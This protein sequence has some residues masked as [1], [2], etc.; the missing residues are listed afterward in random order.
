MCGISGI[1]DANGITEADVDSVRR[2]NSV[3]HHRGPDDEGLYFDNNCALG[4]RRLSIIDLSKDG[5]QPFV[6]DDGRYY[7]VYNGEIYNYIELREELSK[8]GW[9]FKTRTDTEVLLITYQEY[10]PKCLERLNGM[11]AFVVYDLERKTLF[12]ARDRFGIKPLY[13]A[14]VEKKL[15]FASEIKAL[16]KILPGKLSLNYLSL[17]DY[18]TFNRTDVYDETFF[19]EI[20]RI[21]KG[22]Y[23]IFDRSGLQTQTWWDPQNY[24]QQPVTDDMQKAARDIEEILIS[25]VQLRMRSDV[26]VGSCLSGGLDSSV[27]IGILDRHHGLTQEYPTFTASFPSHP[28]DETGY[29]DTLQNRYPFNNF[30]TYPDEKKALKNIRKFVFI[31]DEP[32]T[33]S[34]FYSQYE[35]MQIAKDHGV[36]VLLDGQGGDENFAGYQ[37]FNGFFLYG[38]LRRKQ[39]ARFLNEILK[40]LIRKQHISAYQTLLFQ[41]FP[42][43]LKKKSLLRAVAYLNPDFFY[44]NINKS[45]IYNEFFAVN[46]LNE[47]LAM[48]FKYKLEHLLRMEDRN[49]M[50]F[51]L[52]ARVPYLDYR[53]VEYT[54]GIAENLKIWGAETKYLQKKAVGSYTIPKIMERTDKIGFGTP[55][56]E[57][58]L[59]DDWKKLTEDNYRMLIRSFPEIFRKD[60]PL[61]RTGFDRWKVNQLAIWKELFV[62]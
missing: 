17:F 3:L 44:E 56:D 18:L 39:Y 5:H 20:K 9:H 42:G 31:N 54:L 26:P 25:A 30:R 28:I 16:H 43:S 22:A 4:H 52:E 58:M 55:G 34:S 15:Y 13:Y 6:S 62:D 32:T 35:V 57:W 24:L 40:C 14:F 47:S 10:G 45:R 38:L 59:T 51:S 49:S 7:L 41:I 27:L 33:N 60:V 46:G 50:A 11:F 61:P 48:H 8:K 19:A 36:T 12:F 21:P 53:L 23:A 1:F 2:M 37:Y 29:I